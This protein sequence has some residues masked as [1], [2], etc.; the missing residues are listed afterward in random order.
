ML[1]VADELGPF[2]VGWRAVFLAGAQCAAAPMNARCPW[3]LICAD[4]VRPSLGW[5]LRSAPARR[6][7]ATPRPP[8]AS[9]P[10]LSTSWRV[11]WA[12]TGGASPPRRTLRVC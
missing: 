4:V 6:G 3:V 5:L 10:N 2:L 12:V 9:G 7:L 8:A 11:C 1:E